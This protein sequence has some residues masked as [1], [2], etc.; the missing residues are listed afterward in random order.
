MNSVEV[1][2]RQTEYWLWMRITVR[3]VGHR[4]TVSCRISHALCPF[5]DFLAWLEALTTGVHACSFWWDNEGTDWMLGWRDG[6]LF[7]A[8][9]WYEPPAELNERASR[10][11]VVGA[12]YV[13]FRRF[14]ESAAYDPTRYE[15]MRLGE[16]YARKQGTGLTEEEFRGHLLVKS[17]AEAEGVLQ[18]ITSAEERYIDRRWDRWNAT[19]RRQ[20]FDTFFGIYGQGGFGAPLRTLRSPRVEAWLAEKS[21]V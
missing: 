7:V 20:H 8:R 4:R 19:R 14:V 17:S 11:Q 9:R 1:R 16:W 5:L 3:R 2:F 21:R 18:A 6:S 13:A 12:F 10:C 15:R